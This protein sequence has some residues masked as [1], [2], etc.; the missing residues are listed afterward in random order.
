LIFI[1]VGDLGGKGRLVRGK[2]GE[3]RVLAR[4]LRRA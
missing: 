3:K 2:R 1:I 4:F